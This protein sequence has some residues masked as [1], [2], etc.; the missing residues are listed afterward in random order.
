MIIRS[1]MNRP[2]SEELDLHLSAYR[3]DT[4]PGWRR[5][6]SLLAGVAMAL[7]MT[8]L[9]IRQVYRVQKD[10]DPVFGF[11]VRPGTAVRWQREGNGTSHW[12]NLGVRRRALPDLSRGSILALGDSFTEGWMVN[13]DEVFT[14][15][16]EQRTRD[17]T[18]LPVL[19]AGRSTT[20]VADYIA[21][22]GWYQENLR[23]RWTIVQVRDDDLTSDAW[24]PSKPHFTW[25][26]ALHVAVP[27]PPHRGSSWKALW[28]W[29]Q[30][31]SLFGYGVV[32][33]S[34]FK[35]AIA[36]E[37]PMFRAAYGPRSPSP[38][39]PQ[40]LVASFPIAASLEMLRTAY[41]G[42]LTILYLPEFD[43]RDPTRPTSKLEGVLQSWCSQRA[44]S[45]VNL[46]TKYEELWRRGRSPYGFSNTAF[47]VGHLNA[48]G[49]RAAAELLAPVVHRLI[50]DGLL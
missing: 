24:D 18:K 39:D 26:G 1:L 6:G 44:V 49:H 20:S 9:V 43:P 13:D 7:F 14:E 30:R 2:G 25:Q 45:C 27:R 8:E 3:L 29:R 21:F 35:D 37:P 12:T 32:R 50:R 46:R 5:W 41:G 19:N 28:P 17:V 36:K 48:D 33:I 15:I 23:P 47:N 22:S 34:E 38:P 16:L 4:R 40:T 10:I 31:I 42:R 11:L